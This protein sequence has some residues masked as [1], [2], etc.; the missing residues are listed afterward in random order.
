MSKFSEFETV[1]VTKPE[2]ASSLSVV[3]QD[4]LPPATAYLFGMKVTAVPDSKTISRLEAVLDDET[5]TRYRRFRFVNDQHLFLQA[6]AFLRLL[7]AQTTGQSVDSLRFSTGPYGRPELIVAAGEPPIR[8]NLSHTAGFVAVVVTAT[9]DCGV[10]VE[11][12]GRTTDLDGVAQ[13]FFAPP[14]AQSLLRLPPVERSTR[15]YHYWTL[16][17]SYIKARGRGLN[18]PLGRFYFEFDDEIRL[19]D[20]AHPDWP[21]NRWQWLLRSPTP[22]HTLACGIDTASSTLKTTSAEGESSPFQIHE[23]T[24][25]PVWEYLS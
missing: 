11:W 4:G 15:F 6:H 2:F 17:E 22:N 21:A 3:P 1:T 7:L 13:R 19:V 14:E 10:D 23:F 20:T 16:K 12:Q 8:F 5:L 25:A 24:A 9:A 18:L